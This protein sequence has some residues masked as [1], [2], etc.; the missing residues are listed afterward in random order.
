MANLNRTGLVIGGLALAAL[1][2]IGFTL[3]SPTRR[4]APA[5]PRPEPVGGG[6]VGS[7]AASPH[8]LFRHAGSGANARRLSLAS[9]D[10]PDAPLG[11]TDLQCDR[12]A[13]ASGR[14]ICLRETVGIFST[15]EAVLFDSAFRP[16]ATIKL[17]GTPSRTRISPD[18]RFGAIT[19]FLTGQAHGYASA[20]F[21]TKTTLLDM[22]TGSLLAD[23]EQFHTLRDG[24]DFSSPDFNFWGVTFARDSNTFY[25]SL[26]SAKKTYLVRGDIGARTLTVLRENVECPS[27]SPDNRRVAFKKRVGGDLAPWRFYVLDLATLQEHPI[28][29]EVRSIDD[30]LEW[31]DDEHVLYGASRGSQSAVVDVWMAPVEGPE[32]AR[33]FLLQASSPIVVR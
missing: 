32:P 21:S 13:Y 16:G 5:P 26:W 3:A 18:G 28:A 31:L 12:V 15:F 24:Q 4:A 25:A 27:I 14:G 29:A 8:L 17:D 6:D 33:A 11:A 22:S 2:A 7:L 10:S 23:L 30:Q 1:L 9:L 19:V 20:S